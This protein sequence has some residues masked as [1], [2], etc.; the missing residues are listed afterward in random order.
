M[1]TTMSISKSGVIYTELDTLL[2]T[3]LAIL[4]QLNQDVATKVLESGE[5]H[6][7]LEDGY[8]DVPREVMVE[9]YAQRNEF[10]L[11]QSMMTNIF[12]VIRHM[13]KTILNE[14]MMTPFH[15][16]LKLVV[17]IHP[18]S[19]L[20]EEERTFLKGAIQHN[21]GGVAEIELVDMTVE[22]LTPK[23]CKANYRFMVLY[24][25][26]N[27]M[28]VQT[29]A[30]HQTFMP[31]VAV[32]APALYQAGLPTVDERTECFQELKKHFPDVDSLFDGAEKFNRMLINLHLIDVWYFSIVSDFSQSAHNSSLPDIASFQGAMSGEGATV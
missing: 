21:V 31:E 9:N 27:W 25:W 22:E 14:E 16:K 6:T 1:V 4:G 5:H 30:F 19:N 29:P 23:H 3:H 12:V 26:G 15:G 32:V 28:R 24:D 13:F 20:T 8:P 2:D 11:T 10:T 17:N 18:Y 7:R